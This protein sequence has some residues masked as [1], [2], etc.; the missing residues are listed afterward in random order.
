MT[1]ATAFAGTLIA[2]D[3]SIL[4]AGVTNP[5]GDKLGTVDD[6]MID[7][8][9]GRVIYAVMSFGG[10][11][12]LGAKYHPVPWELLKLDNANDGIV[13]VDLDKDR[14]KAAPNYDGEADWT[15]RYASEVDSFYGINR[16]P[17]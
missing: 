9:S 12:G 15:R 6:L 1:D 14:L 10:L 17:P 5:A 2:A 16:P 8:A 13:V 11:L 4:G 7:S 3:K